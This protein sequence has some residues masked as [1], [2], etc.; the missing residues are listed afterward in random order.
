MHKFHKK[1]KKNYEGFLCIKTMRV[2]NEGGGGEE[3]K[4]RNR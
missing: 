1:I 4:R 2:N 3:R